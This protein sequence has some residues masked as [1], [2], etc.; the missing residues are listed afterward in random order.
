MASDLL[1]RNT[2]FFCIL[3]CLLFIGV[4]N[5][6]DLCAAPCKINFRKSHN[7]SEMMISC[8]LEIGITR[9]IYFQNE[10]KWYIYQCFN[11]LS[12]IRNIIQTFGVT[13]YMVILGISAP[14]SDAQSVKIRNK[15]NVDIFQPIITNLVSL[16]MF[17]ATVFATVF[18]VLA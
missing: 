11:C 14:L 6:G 15:H 12:F 16:P 4:Q 10:H 17:S 3:L 7:V 8:N 9:S 5:R 1:I 18:W 13:P 2:F